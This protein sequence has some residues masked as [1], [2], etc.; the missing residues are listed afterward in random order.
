MT[1]HPCRVRNFLRQEDND[2]FDEISEYTPA[3]DVTSARARFFQRRIRVLLYTE[4]AHFYFRHRIR[5]TRVGPGGE[6]GGGS[7]CGVDR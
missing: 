2:V 7:R 5:G 6:G 1:P 3:Q 4:R